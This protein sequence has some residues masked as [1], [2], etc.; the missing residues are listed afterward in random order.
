[1]DNMTYTD[2]VPENINEELL[3]K[4]DSDLKSGI[5][6]LIQAQSSVFAHT[7]GA[8]V[9]E[10][11]ENTDRF[12]KEMQNVA[13]TLKEIDEISLKT[14]MLSINT[15]IE[16]AHA[17]SAGKGFAVIAQEIGTLSNQTT[18]CT[19]KVGEVDKELI[20]ATETNQSILAELSGYLRTFSESNEKIMD[21]VRKISAIEE[22]GF[23]TT[24]LAKRV[25]NHA[26]YIRDL[27][28]N[29]GKN[30][31]ISDHHTCAFGKWY[32]ANR[33]KYAHMPDF[34]SIYEPHKAFHDT[35]IEFNRTANVGVLIGMLGLSREMLVKFLALAEAF[36]NEMQKH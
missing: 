5:M 32:D 27:L 26:D 9:S 28:K 4:G 17:G 21:D 14:R 34:A 18:K 35:A 13:Q 15:A 29:I 19:V 24:T 6:S 36:K 12:Q 1:V 25:E 16:S 2:S 8:C 10:I 23:I 20:G 30:A 22:N 3:I 11:A 7:I 33:D 31:R